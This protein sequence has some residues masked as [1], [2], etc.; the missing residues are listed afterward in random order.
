M[1]WL[2]V[3]IFLTTAHAAGPKVFAI[4]NNQFS[5]HEIHA[6]VE[7]PT[8]ADYRKFI[9]GWPL[10]PVESRALADLVEREFE[11]R[12]VTHTSNHEVSGRLPYVA[13]HIFI[14]HAGIARRPLYVRGKARRTIRAAVQ[15]VHLVS[16]L[17]TT[18]IPFT[19]ELRQSRPTEPWSFRLI[20]INF[21][22]AHKTPAKNAPV[23]SRALESAYL[24]CLD[25]LAAKS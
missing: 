1:S 3:L 19:F 21:E 23:L 17:K 22:V 10:D 11:R 24:A 9:P 2:G 14:E 8:P 25:A 6:L 18:S 15:F 12:L 20:D 4:L 7:A 13:V 5:L 16:G